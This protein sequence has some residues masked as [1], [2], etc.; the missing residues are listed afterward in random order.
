LIDSKTL[1]LDDSIT[2]RISGTTISFSG[3]RKD[4]ARCN[5]SILLYSSDFSYTKNGLGST[6]AS[7]KGAFVSKCSLKGLQSGTYI[8]CLNVQTYPS[9]Y[10]V[11][12]RFYLE[13]G[14]IKLY[15]TERYNSFAQLLKEA[16]KVD[17]KA[18]ASINA[19]TFSTAE[20]RV[21]VQK[22]TM[23]IIKGKTTDADKVHAIYQWIAEHIAY[24]YNAYD[25]GDF[26]ISYQYNQSSM[27]Y[28]ADMAA[29]EYTADKVLE[30]RTSICHG[31]ASLL[32]A[33]ARFAGIPALYVSVSSNQIGHAINLLYYDGKWNIADSTWDCIFGYK[34][35]TSF[36]TMDNMAYLRYGALGEYEK[37][38]SMLKCKFY[39]MEQ[40]IYLAS[41]NYS[42][43][44]LTYPVV[45]SGAI[46]I[47][48]EE[49]IV[50]EEGQ[51][52]TDIMVTPYTS[53]LLLSSSD[54]P[55]QR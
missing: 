12:V 16:D 54:P 15:D 2:F 55:A 23:E 34:W 27:S 38:S 31:F 49:D 33:M 51:T 39:Y 42:D 21:L 25:P 37:Q 19:S 28:A 1:L 48:P 6:T 4:F 14:K 5:I 7:G 10:T 43:P 30:R 17:R 3:T 47:L 8:A 11:N 20:G 26:F 32:A 35:N 24:D 40:S 41:Q 52:S 18:A 50:L 53:E 9:Y 44:Q 22:Q 36:I 29:G 46:N 13:N 45:T